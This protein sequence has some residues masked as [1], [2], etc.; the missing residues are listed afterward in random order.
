M[1]LKPQDV[2]LA[3]TDSEIFQVEG[4]H[5]GNIFKIACQIFLV[6]DF[7]HITGIG[8]AGEETGVGVIEYIG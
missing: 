8:A 3:L 1:V 6:G 2:L 7:C 5:I 4:L